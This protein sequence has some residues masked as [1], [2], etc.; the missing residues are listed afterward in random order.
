MATGSEVH[1]AVNA[2]AALLEKGHDVSVV[3]MPSLELF[4]LQSDDYKESV[5]PKDIKKR[6]AIE[7]GASFGWHKYVGLDGT[8]VGIDRF[9]ESGPGDE[10][11]EFFGFTVDNVVEQYLS[12]N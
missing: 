2:Q 10:V 3:S 8:V 11:I 12:L 1:L 9:G 6:V 4:D 5:L 7:M